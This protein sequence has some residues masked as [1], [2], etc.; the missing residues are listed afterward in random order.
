[1]SINDD[2]SSN[3]HEETVVLHRAAAQHDNTS[4]STT[5]FCRVDSVAPASPAATAGLQVGDEIL[6]FGPCPTEMSEVAELVRSAAA[7]HA[8]V[9]LRVLRRN[10]NSNSSEVLLLRLAPRPWNGRGLLGCHI[11]PV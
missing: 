1:M 10:D 8:A 4:S 2:N 9:E 6:A 3:N 5:P 7:E 11:V